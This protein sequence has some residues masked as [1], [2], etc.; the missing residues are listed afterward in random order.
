MQLLALASG[1]AVDTTV[2]KEVALGI[3]TNLEEF[4]K[5][6]WRALG[7][8]TVS[9]FE[10]LPLPLPAA[11]AFGPVSD[12]TPWLITILLARDLTI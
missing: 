1:L 4:G 12:S 5:V 6:S 9:F 10:E 2:S 8:K 7:L 11:E 3:A